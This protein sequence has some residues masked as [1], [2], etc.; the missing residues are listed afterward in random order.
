M[1]D[2][3]YMVVNK[4]IYYRDQ[5]YLVLDSQLKEKILHAAHD[6]PVSC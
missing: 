3:P 2:D 4:V 6:S 1:I 5:I